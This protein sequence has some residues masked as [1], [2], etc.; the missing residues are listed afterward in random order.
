MVH[1]IRQDVAEGRKQYVHFLHSSLPCREAQH[2]L[3]LCGGQRPCGVPSPHPE[4]VAAPHQPPHTQPGQDGSQTFSGELTLGLAQ[5]EALEVSGTEPAVSHMAGPRAMPQP[6]TPGSR[7][8]SPW[9]P[10]ICS[11]P[12]C[13]EKHPQQLSQVRAGAGRAA[14]ASACIWEQT[15]C[16]V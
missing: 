16:G 12:Y 2:K 6:Y 11:C 13:G 1:K 10:S 9:D 4:T 7:Y 8:Q 3:F 14:Q 5:D 15:L